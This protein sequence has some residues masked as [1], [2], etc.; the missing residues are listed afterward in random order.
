MKYNYNFNR[1]EDVDP[2]GQAIENI[3]TTINGDAANLPLD[4]VLNGVESFTLA[5]GFELNG[6]GIGLVDKG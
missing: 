5:C 6:S 2:T 4:T 1:D 3:S